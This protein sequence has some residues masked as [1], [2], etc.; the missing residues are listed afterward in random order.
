MRFVVLGAIRPPVEKGVWVAAFETLCRR[1]EA[2][3]KRPKDFKLGEA[4]VVPIGGEPGW[5][6]FVQWGIRV[7]PPVMIS[8]AES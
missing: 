8:V 7:A 1:M 6:G 5:L 4:D 2:A 3:V